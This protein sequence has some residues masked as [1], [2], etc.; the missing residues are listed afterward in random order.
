MARDFS[1]RTDVDNTDPVNYP[2]A[3][4]KDSDPPSSKNGTRVEESALLGDIFQLWLKLLRDASITAND[5]PDN[6]S[7]GYQLLDALVAKIQEVTGS[8]IDLKGE[9]DCS[10]NPNYPAARTGDAYVVSVA[11]KIGGASGKVVDVGDLI[12]AKNDNAGGDEVAVGNDWFVLERNLDQATETA[13]GILKLATQALADGGTNDTDAMTPLKSSKSLVRN[14]GNTTGSTETAI[15]ELEIGIWDMDSTTTVSIPHGV[16]FT[17]KRVSVS[18]IDDL[19]TSG[20][21][22][23]SPSLTSTEPQISIAWTSTN[24]LISRKVAGFFDSTDFNSAAQNRGF[25]SIEHES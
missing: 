24:I 12:V 25:L 20:Y 19:G 4:I 21:D 16:G 15:K 5:N 10:T 2:D 6:V 9:I 11:G 3:R 18:I 14:G 1:A 22:G 7:N 17:I 23:V 8:L 13:A